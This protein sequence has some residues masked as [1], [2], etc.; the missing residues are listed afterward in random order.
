MVLAA[1]VAEVAAAQRLRSVTS[2][3]VS[4]LHQ[5]AETAAQV[6]SHK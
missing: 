1:E 6:A 2:V 5:M 4:R 3:A